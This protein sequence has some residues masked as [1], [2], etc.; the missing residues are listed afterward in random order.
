MRR[1]L[2]TLRLPLSCRQSPPTACRSSRVARNARAVRNVENAL[3]LHTQRDSADSTPTPSAA[4]YNNRGISKAEI[5]DHG[6][7]YHRLLRRRYVID[8]DHAAA[9]SNRGAAKAYLSQYEAAIADYD[10]AIRLQPDYA[11]AHFNRRRCQSLLK[12]IRG[13]PVADYDEAI[14]L[15]PDDASRLLTTAVRCQSITSESQCEAA[16]ADYDEAIRLQPDNAYAYD[17]R[18]IAMRALEQA[19]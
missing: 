9:Y 16:I 7:R 5:G 18:D 11:S 17:Y 15:Q 2:L 8:P 4:A 12:P 14:R 10:E 13:A 1:I 19:E 3:P 6:R